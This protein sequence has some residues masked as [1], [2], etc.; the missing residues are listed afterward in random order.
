ME[1]DDIHAS[2]SQGACFNEETKLSSVPAELKDDSYSVFYDPS[3]HK[4]EKK[5]AK[6][7]KK[8]RKQAKASKRKNRRKQLNRN[9]QQIV[10][11]QVARSIFICQN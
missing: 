5:K 9:W 2:M 1:N 6:A 7:K 10:T 8:K 4:L 3:S 11:G